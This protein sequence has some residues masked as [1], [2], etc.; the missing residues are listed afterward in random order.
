MH[1]WKR[2]ET[3]SSENHRQQRDRRLVRGVMNRAT[4]TLLH[5]ASAPPDGDAFATWVRLDDA[6]HLLRADLNQDDIILY[7]SAG[8]VFFHAVLAPSDVLTPPDATDLMHWSGNP[9]DSWGVAYSTDPRKASIEPPLA[10]SPSKAIAK[11]EQLVFARRFAGVSDETSIELLQKLMHLYGL[12]YLEERSAYCRLDER[13][14]LEDVVTITRT[15]DF[16]GHGAGRTVVT[17]KRSVIDEY[18]G[19]TD[20]TMVRMFEITRWNPRS[21][22]GWTGDHDA[23]LRTDDDLI[24]RRHVEPQHAGYMRGVQIVSSRIPQKDTAAPNDLEDQC[25]RKYESFVAIDW[26]HDTVREISTEPGQTADYFVQSDLPFEMSPAFFR[27]EVLLRYKSDSDKYTLQDRS[28][29][30]RGTWHI[31]TYDV[32]DAG[33]VHTYIVYLR[34]LPYEEQLHWKA[35]NEPPKAWISKR[36]VRT[37]FEGIWDGEYDALQ[38]LRQV[39]RQLNEAAPLWWSHRTERAIEGVHYPVT[40][41]PD[42]WA[43]EILRLDQLVIEGL[44]GKGLRALAA[45]MG[46][47]PDPA[48]ASLK[49]VEECLMGLGWNEERAREVTAPMHSLHYYRSMVKAHSKGKEE[50]QLRKDVLRKYRTY[51]QHFRA[52][53]A[54]CD[55]G[56]RTIHDALSSATTGGPALPAAAPGARGP[57]A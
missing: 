55:A 54:D 35:H 19:I 5:R 30:C 3:V 39:V 52:L 13:G 44:R 46:R 57:V 36:A 15:D 28:I 27:P 49:L 33:Q 31:Q 34:R 21:F 48:L 11:G 50:K 56:L 29:S 47:A 32:N 23:E 4:Q 7:C 14:D 45:S 24:Y 16:G 1:C 10:R 2:P 17:I 40:T 26:K 51:G 42:E 20:T 38:S 25:A 6:T 12:Y 8:D 9:Y 43:D 41:S 53:C 18:M 22:G 37:D